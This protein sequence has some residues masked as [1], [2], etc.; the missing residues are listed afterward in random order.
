[1]V[2]GLLAYRHY[3]SNA[4]MLGVH[5]IM[6]EILQYLELSYR[7]PFSFLDTPQCHLE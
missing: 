5:A 7:D 1:M 6:G 2:D 4:I 3:A